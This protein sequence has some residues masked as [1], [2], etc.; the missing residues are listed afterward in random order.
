MGLASM[1]RSIRIEARP[2]PVRDAV[3]WGREQLSS[4]A[5]AA[6]GSKTITGLVADAESL[7]GFVRRF[8]AK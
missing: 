2:K 5:N 1:A 7:I 8:R 6:R 4:V 3:D